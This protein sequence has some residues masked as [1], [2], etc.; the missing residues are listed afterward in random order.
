MSKPAIELSDLACTFVSDDSGVT[1]IYTAVK[2]VNLTVADGEFV[3][4]VGPTGCGKSTLLNMSAG[5]LEPS[6]GSVKIFGEPLSGL[7]RRAGYMFQA[8]SLMPWKSAL[9]NVAAGLVFEGV[10]VEEARERA[11]EWLARVG[12]TGFED[13]YPHHLSGGMRK[14]VAMAADPHQGSRHH[15]DGRVLLGARHPDAPADGKTNF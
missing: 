9:D 10:P 12:L 13:R 6:A 14:R 7:N 11:R 4:V 15:S 5:L 1:S 2:G 8:D 3:S